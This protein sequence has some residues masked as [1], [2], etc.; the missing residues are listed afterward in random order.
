MLILMFLLLSDPLLR[1]SETSLFQPVSQDLVAVDAAGALFVLDTAEKQVVVFDPQ[2]GARSVFG[3]EGQGPGEF[4]MPTLLHVQEQHV[5]VFDLMQR[6]INVFDLKGQ[7]RATHTI[8]GEMVH[9]EKS[10]QGWVEFSSMTMSESST[11]VPLRLFQFDWSD[12]RVL[13]SF[14]S[15]PMLGIKIE[16]GK[17][18]MP[19][20]PAPQRYHVATWGNWL[21][22]GHKNAFQIDLYDLKLGKITTTIQRSLPQIPFDREWG[23]RQL[24]TAQDRL[25]SN[26]TIEFSPDF[27]DA[28]P[29][30]QALAFNPFGQLEVLQYQI[31]EGAKEHRL[32]FTVEGDDAVSP[33]SSFRDLSRILWSDGQLA[34]FQSFDGENE[35]MLIR[36]PLRELKNALTETPFEDEREGGMSLQVEVHGG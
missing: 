35:L 28:F 1:L 13:G 6:N 23:N 21:A 18:A 27:P 25:K 22:F 31:A 14:P 33:L 36:C 2:T 20:N 15:E 34:W 10:T 7:W 17:A 11:E 3:R 4:Q 8:S 19:F 29:P 16:N 9:V 32:C 12:H 26:I 30:I 24:K 5:L